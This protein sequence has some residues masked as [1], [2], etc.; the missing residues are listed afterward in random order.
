MKVA[1]FYAAPETLQKAFNSIGEVKQTMLV[2]GKIVGLWDWNKKQG[3]IYAYYFLDIEKS[4]R[5]LLEDQ[6]KKM[7]QFLNQNS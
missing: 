3:K 5:E 2:D 6:I 7:E 1:F 4:K